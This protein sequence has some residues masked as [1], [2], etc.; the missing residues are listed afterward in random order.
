MEDSRLKKV[1]DTIVK[2]GYDVPD[3]TTFESD[4]RDDKKL[5]LVRDRLVED[6]YDLPEFEQFKIDMF[7]AVEAEPQQGFF[8]GVKAQIADAAKQGSSSG[9]SATANESVLS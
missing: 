9:L 7:G 4:M 8:T 5:T 1:Y 6:G 3:Y 2:E